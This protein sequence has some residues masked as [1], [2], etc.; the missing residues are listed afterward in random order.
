M[1]RP[2]GFLDL[3]QDGLE[4]LLELAAELGPGDQRAQV[5]RDDLLVLERLGHVASDDALG[6]PFH[7][8]GLADAG[9]ADQDR[10]VLGSG[11]S[12]PG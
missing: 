5:Q 6:Q 1:I 4:T 11:G 12:G 3:A 9:F 7:D 2:S 8:G 10:V